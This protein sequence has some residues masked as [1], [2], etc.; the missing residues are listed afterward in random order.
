MLK[1]VFGAVSARFEAVLV[2]MK[3][4]QLHS[5]EEVVYE[6]ASIYLVSSR[7]TSARPLVRAK[8]CRMLRLVSRSVPG[9]IH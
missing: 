4:R 2:Y 1:F 8:R 6:L 3:L 9:F 5:R 7:L